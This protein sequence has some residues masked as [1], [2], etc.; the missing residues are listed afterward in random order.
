MTNPFLKTG[1]TVNPN[2]TVVFE[3]PPKGTPEYTRFK[4]ILVSLYMCND[5]ISITFLAD[6]DLVLAER[7]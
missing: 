3:H 4:E 7:N 1:R 6:G 2:T 5:E